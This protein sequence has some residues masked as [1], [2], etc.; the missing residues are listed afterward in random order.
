MPTFGTPSVGGG[1]GT[2]LAVPKPAGLADG[3]ILVVA[4]RSQDSTGST[5]WAAPSGFT[6]VSAAEVLPSAGFRVGGIWVKKITDAASEPTSYAFTGPASRNVGISVRYV[7][8]DTGDLTVVSAPTYGGGANGASASYLASRSLSSTPAVTFLA[9]GVEATAGISHVPS[10]VDSSFTVIASAQSSLDSSTTG[11]RTALTLAY[12]VEPAATS[13]RSDWG[14]SGGSAAAIYAATVKG[15]KQAAPTPVGIPVKLGNGATA[16][17]SILDGAGTRVTPARIR[18]TKEPLTVAQ[19]LTVSG[20]TMGH[21]GASAVSGMPEMSRKGYQYAAYDRGYRAVEFS[22]NRTSDGV[23]FGVHDATLNRTS[24]ETGLPNV[25]AMTW[26]E[27]QTHLNSLNSGGTP[28]PYYR[29]EDFLDEF[30][31]EGIVHVDPKYAGGN[32][33]PFL[34]VLDAHGGPEKIIVKFVGTGSGATGIADAAKA[35]GYTTAGYFYQTDWEAG[36]IDAEQSHWDIIGIEYG[37]SVDAFSRTTT[38]AYP[39]IRSYGKPILAHILPTQAVYDAV[40]TKIEEGGWTGHWT[41][42]V[43]GVGVVAPVGP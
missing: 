13:P 35:R 31:R 25:S 7:P 4:V 11:S 33:A 32:M 18:V 38:G 17:L 30:T 15:G 3:D 22:A 39:G 36:K 6:R 41:A 26:A 9:V 24:Q 10:V 34:G 14:F 37:A 21:R 28:I 40:K 12:K 19:A 2:S 16:Y 8:D 29:L 43:S 42:Q 1:T 20:L 23:Y 5:P 27:V